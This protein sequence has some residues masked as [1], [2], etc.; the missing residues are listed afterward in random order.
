M[1]HQSPL[2][3]A[4]QIKYFIYLLWVK[5]SCS[6]CCCRSRPLG[7]SVE[8]GF[9]VELLKPC[10]SSSEHLLRCRLFKCSHTWKILTVQ[11]DDAANDRPCYQLTKQAKLLF[12]FCLNRRHQRRKI[13]L[14]C[15]LWQIIIKDD[16]EWQENGLNHRYDGCSA[17]S[18]MFLIW[19]TS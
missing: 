13:P 10:S 5:G 1:M 6:S 4:A 18:F 9:Q 8:L 16:T 2:T 12:F 7:R 17:T 11:K 15:W 19:P 14:K 3:D